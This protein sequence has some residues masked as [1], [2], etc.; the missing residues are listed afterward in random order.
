MTTVLVPRG[1]A[2]GD[3]VAALLA[4]AGL[5]AVIAP[6]IGREPPSDPARLTRALADLAVGAR[7]DGLAVT[8]A[9]T[10]DVLV[11]RGVT[12]SHGVRVGAVG[13]ATAA[14]LEAA[15]IDVA[16]QPAAEASGEA[17][18][19]VWPAAV[20]RVLVLR[21][22]IG[23]PQLVAGLRDRG[24]EV[25]D[26]AAYRTVARELAAGTRDALATGEITAALVTSGS[27]ARS[28]AS[29]LDT[30][31]TPLVAC[32]GPLTAADARA[33]GLDVDVI[34]PERTVESLVSA[35]AAHLSPSE[36]VRP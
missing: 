33:A 7:Y 34:A 26:V 3:R 5:D 28:L 30:G 25:D 10:V 13:A 17:L 22:E 15:A 19:A 23:G 1:G 4:A 11:E 9:A 31:S 29:Q 6:L 18:A 35:L 14:A 21:S 16:F 2:W 8:S 27:V 24:H 12:V 32:L 20:R 36:E